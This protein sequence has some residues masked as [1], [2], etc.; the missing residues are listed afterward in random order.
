[1]PPVVP[2]LLTA[3]AARQG[4][5]PALVM[6]DLMVTYAELEMAS[7][8][9]AR[10]LIRYGVRRGDRVALWIPKSMEAIVA[11]W[12]VMKAGATYVPVDA[13]APASRLAYVARQCDIS[14]LVTPAAR[15]PELDVVFGGQT[16]MR[17]VWYTDSTGDAQPLAGVPAIPWR[18]LESESTERPDVAMDE[19]D[20]AHIVYTSGSTGEPKGAMAAHRILLAFVK[21]A[22]DTF[23]VTYEDRVPGHS[24][25]NH[26]LSGFELFLAVHAGATVYP[27]S[28]RIAVFP[29]AVAKSWSE[30][31]LTIWYV[32]SSILTSMLNRGNLAACDLSSLRL[33]VFCGEAFPAKHL[34]QLMKLAPQARFVALYGRTETKVNMMHEVRSLPEDDAPLPLGKPCA[35]FRALVLDESERPVRDGEVGELWLSGPTLMRGYWG[36]PELTA[37]TLKS[38]EVG[39]GV[40]LLACRT[41]DLVKRHEDGNLEFRGRVDH[42]VKVRGHR[43][44][45]GEIEF[46]LT[47]HAAVERAVVLALPQEDVGHRLKA[48][49]IVKPGLAIDEIALKRHCATNLPTYMVPE[50]IELHSSL[51]LTSNGKVDRPVLLRQMTSASP[52]TAKTGR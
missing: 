50:T 49:V 40:S 42:Q 21:W 4:E 3:T 6:D 12:G 19:D 27:V 29:T 18:E 47:L 44:E 20:L 25:I 15:A 5:R 23:K 11:L 41:G 8:R 34:R 48:A 28:P 43:V 31:R 51:P 1:M 33:V 30:Q 10:S 13:A 7:N 46:A 39:P 26:G 14:A 45:L 36:L 16:P 9:V 17:G 2:D 22:D 37:Q 38:I 52:R 24:A 32:M 35:G